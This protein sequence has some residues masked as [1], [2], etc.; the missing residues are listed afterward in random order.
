MKKG[1]L[2]LSINA[3][4]VIVIAITILGLALTFVRNMFVQ[5]T[6]TGLEVIR[7]TDLSKLVNPPTRDNPLTVT[8]S[9]IELRNNNQKV[10]GVAFMN[11]EA[12]EDSFTLKVIGS[13]G[14]TVCDSTGNCDDIKFIYTQTA[15][16]LQPDEIGYWKIAINPAKTSLSDPETYLASI[17]ITGTTTEKKADIIITVKP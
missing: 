7:G 6:E 10:I 16:Q 1:A 14:T 4:V 12:T 11:T 5:T 13:D 3:I 2:E 9:N 17:K 8:P 15:A